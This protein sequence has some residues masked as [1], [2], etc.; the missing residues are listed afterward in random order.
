M[1]GAVLQAK[2]NHSATLA[3]L[4]DEVQGKVLNE[5]VAVV[6]QGLH[7]KSLESQT[8]SQSLDFNVLST[9]QG[10]LRAKVK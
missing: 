9:A 7:R 2:G 4:H 1:N 8:E 6:L 10:H 5:V 3:P